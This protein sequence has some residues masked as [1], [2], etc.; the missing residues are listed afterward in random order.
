MCA[1]VLKFKKNPGKFLFGNF[2]AVSCAADTVILA[3]TTAKSTAGKEN[4]PT[5]SCTADTGFFPIMKGSTGSLYL[6][7]G[8]TKSKRRSPVNVTVSWAK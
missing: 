1:L 6:R 7:R 5:A 8:L 2:F 3:E 4:R